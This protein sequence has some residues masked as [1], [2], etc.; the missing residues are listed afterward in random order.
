M[1]HKMALRG[2]GPTNRLQL[3]LVVSMQPLVLRLRLVVALPGG[4]AGHGELIP[5]AGS[6]LLWPWA[7]APRSASLAERSPPPPTWG[8]Q[9][10]GCGGTAQPTLGPIHLK[11]CRQRH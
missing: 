9:R 10:R 3:Q 7:V 5:C 2:R 4:T 1:G 6:N 8:H 11:A